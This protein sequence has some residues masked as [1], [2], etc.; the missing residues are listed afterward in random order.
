MLVAQRTAVLLVYEF[1]FLVWICSSKYNCSINIQQP[2][3]R[4]S[5]NWCQNY[6]GHNYDNRNQFIFVF[7]PF[8]YQLHLVKYLNQAVMLDIIM[9]HSYD[10]L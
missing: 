3:I 5:L 2:M 6:H 1:H 7:T 4:E 8:E 9:S 10:D